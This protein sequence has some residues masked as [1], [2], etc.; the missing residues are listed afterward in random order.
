[1]VSTQLHLPVVC[2]IGA[3][4]RAKDRTVILETRLSWLGQLSVKVSLSSSCFRA[5]RELTATN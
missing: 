3:F 4:S 5:L 2:W 1:M